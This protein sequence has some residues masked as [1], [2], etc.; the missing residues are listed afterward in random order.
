MRIIEDVEEFE[1][2][3]L[4]RN[5]VICSE[6]LEMARKMSRTKKG[7]EIVG[8][9]ECGTGDEGVVERE[10]GELVRTS[11]YFGHSRKTC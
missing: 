11:G 4:D 1:W 9:V 7:G 6:G 8:Y 10:L 2:D 5:R 3:A